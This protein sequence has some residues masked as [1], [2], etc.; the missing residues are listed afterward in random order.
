MPAKNPATK[1][2]SGAAIDALLD[3]RRFYNP[4]SDFREKATI[5]DESIYAQAAADTEGFWAKVASELDWF[6]TWNRVLE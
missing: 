5:R 1:P 4:S 3:E 2:S 6:V